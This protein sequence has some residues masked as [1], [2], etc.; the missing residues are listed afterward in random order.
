M[1]FEKLKVFVLALKCFQVILKEVV[2]K[3]FKITL[4]A[5]EG[6]SKPLQPSSD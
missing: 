5:T 6:I 1:I 2:V 3:S 4:E